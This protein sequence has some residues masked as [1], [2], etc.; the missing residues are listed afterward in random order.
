[1][2][3][4][5]QDQEIELQRALSTARPSQETLGDWSP[6]ED[7]KHKDLEMV[8]CLQGT[9]PNKRPVRPVLGK[10]RGRAGDK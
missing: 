5:A 1:M 2:V 10:A 8:P 9:K 7:R 3:V 4:N 6:R